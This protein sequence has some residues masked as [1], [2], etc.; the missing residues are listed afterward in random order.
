MA[1]FVII[2]EEEEQARSLKASL[3]VLKG[4][5]GKAV[6]A[7]KRREKGAEDETGEKRDSC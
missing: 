1:C 5:L 2:G 7:L 4:S 6:E 3:E